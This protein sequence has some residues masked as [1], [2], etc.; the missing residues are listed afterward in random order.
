MPLMG[1][2]QDRGFR[3]GARDGWADVGRERQSAG[4]DPRHAGSGRRRRRWR[5]CAMATCCASMRTTDVLDV[6]SPASIGAS[7]R[8]RSLILCANARGVGPRAVFAVPRQ[9]LF[10]GAGRIVVSGLRSDLVAPVCWSRKRSSNAA[11]RGC[12]AKPSP[13]EI[14]SSRLTPA[15]ERNGEMLNGAESCE[16]AGDERQISWRQVHDQDAA[17]FFGRASGRC[18]SAELFARAVQQPH[19]HRRQRRAG[20]AGVAPIISKF[21]IGL[22]V[23]DHHR[24]ERQA[25][26]AAPRRGARFRVRSLPRRCAVRMP[27]SLLAIAGLSDSGHRNADAE[28]DVDAS[29]AAS[30]AA[31]AR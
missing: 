29:A 25:R 6:V 21:E 20:A 4:G 19:A 12:G 28:R 31:C 22:A 26:P 11:S 3:G 24:G 7:A 30:S 5:R 14:S 23:I 17:A 16:V 13:T 1:A 27:L 15:A 9:R 18:A 8:R 10:G 2:L